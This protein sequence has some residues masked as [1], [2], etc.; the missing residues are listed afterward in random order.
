[1][2]LFRKKKKKRCEDKIEHLLHFPYQVLQVGNPI[3]PLQSLT[4][5]LAAHLSMLKGKDGAWRCQSLAY[6]QQGRQDFL[7][8]RRHRR[9]CARC[10]SNPIAVWLKSY[11]ETI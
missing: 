3:K 2:L 6:K 7:N 8:E 10:L 11:M 4:F 9:H 1:M 5:V